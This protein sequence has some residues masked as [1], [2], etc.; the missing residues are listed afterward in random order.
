MI[1]YFLNN[2][3]MLWVLITVVFLILELTS[4]D[5]M[6]MCIAIG[7]VAA[8]VVSACGAGWVVDIVT[9]MVVSV[10]LL[11]FVRP[12]ALKYLHR[13]DK[14]VKTNADALIGKEGKVVETI[15]PGESGYVAVDG[16][17][18]RA[19]TRGTI[20]LEKGETVVIVDRKSI[21]VT[22]QRKA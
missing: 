4:G 5:F 1:D 16:D 14:N 13:K 7:A 11:A 10:A 3:W 12:F 18:W 20:T 6:F 8:A 9:W 21:V 17:N 2:V 19:V 15:V 22:V